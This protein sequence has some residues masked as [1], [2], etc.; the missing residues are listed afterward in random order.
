MKLPWS[1][2]ID[3]PDNDGQ[4]TGVNN[5]GLTYTDQVSETDID[6]P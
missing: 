1:T 6:G 5:D 3:E 2:E 4:N